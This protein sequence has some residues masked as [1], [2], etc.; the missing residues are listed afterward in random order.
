MQRVKETGFG[1][2]QILAA[3][4]LLLA[5][6]DTSMAVI[7]VIV[8]ISFTAAGIGSLWFY[9]TMARQM[10]GGRVSLY[11]G[12]I[13]FEMGAI[14]LALTDVSHYYILLYLIILHAFQGLV[15]TLRALESRRIG[16][17]SYKLKLT[18]GLLDFCLAILC[19]IFIRQQTT[20][21]LIYAS[22]L[23]YSAV[24]RIVSALRKRSFIYIQ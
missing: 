20:A 1:I 8:G 22:G 4:S 5:P 24:F 6:K 2:L 9:F 3:L 18:H 7:L 10:V 23:F 15:R 17:E 19:I 11:K 14:A 12:I 21:V 13:L 16:A